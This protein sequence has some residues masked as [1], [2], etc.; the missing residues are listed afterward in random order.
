MVRQFEREMTEEE[1]QALTAQMAHRSKDSSLP[2][3]CYLVAMLSVIVVVI[4]LLSFA[5]G[6]FGYVAWGTAGFIALLGFGACIQ[7][8][9]E[10]PRHRRIYD[11]EIR[12][13]YEAALADGRVSITEIESE[14]VLITDFEIGHQGEEVMYLFDCGVNSTVLLH[15]Y[16][17]EKMGETPHVQ[18]R[19]VTTVVSEICLGTFAEKGIFSQTEVRFL[20]EIDDPSR[21]QFQ[22]PPSGTIL[23]GTPSQALDRLIAEYNSATD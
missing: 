17:Y 9:R 12:P 13:L 11:L 21:F 6:V 14:S 19:I 4:G 20:R 3:G 10:G 8:A 22:L 7:V 5:S 2:I 23:A 18:L 1:R 15:G 16:D